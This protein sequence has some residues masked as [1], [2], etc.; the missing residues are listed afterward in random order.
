MFLEYLIHADLSA[1][2]VLYWKGEIRI[3]DLPQAVAA[4]QHP[5]AFELLSR[6]IER[7]CQYFAKQGVK[8]DAVGWTIDLWSRLGRDR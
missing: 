1:H 3:I 2:N 4:D 5:G 7:I 8:T 6:D